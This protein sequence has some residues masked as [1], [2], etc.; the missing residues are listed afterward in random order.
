MLK[1][2]KTRANEKSTWLAVI[3]FIGTMAALPILDARAV[4]VNACAA[5]T[6]ILMGA[7]TSGGK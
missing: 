5:L 6:G 4:I 7:N 2:L 3:G 1:W